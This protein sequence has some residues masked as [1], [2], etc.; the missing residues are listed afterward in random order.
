[1]CLKT[2]VGVFAPLAHTPSPTVEKGQEVGIETRSKSLSG[3]QSQPQYAGCLWRAV[4]DVRGA[5]PA[6]RIASKPSAACPQVAEHHSTWE[7]EAAT[8]CPRGRKEYKRT[9]IGLRY[10]TK[11]W[12]AR[13]P[14]ARREDCP[15]GEDARG[16]RKPTNISQ[17]PQIC[18]SH[19]LWIA[20]PSD[21][22][23]ATSDGAI[24]TRML[25]P[26]VLCVRAAGGLSSVSGDQMLS[27]KDALRRSPIAGKPVLAACGQHRWPG[28]PTNRARNPTA[29]RVSLARWIRGI[30]T[31]LG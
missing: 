31:L 21:R 15:A 26:L 18:H 2:S 20:P 19:L 28:T 13:R 7:P 17:L 27:R 11:G 8:C 4:H 30:R 22:R 3:K 23:L 5:V 25:L 9:P 10:R 29:D 12:M 6:F 16:R 14:D 1:M 24:A